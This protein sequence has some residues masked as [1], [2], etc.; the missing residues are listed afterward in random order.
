[1]AWLVW[2]SERQS[3]P[4]WDL[5]WSFSLF[6][7]CY[8]SGLSKVKRNLK[9]NRSL[10]QIRSVSVVLEVH[11]SFEW[12]TSSTFTVITGK[13]SI[14]VSY[15]LWEYVTSIHCSV[16]SVYHLLDELPVVH[17]VIIVV[18]WY[19]KFSHERRRHVCREW[20]ATHVSLVSLCICLVTT[21]LQR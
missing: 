2:F 1:M 5:A 4:V 21:D 6:E 14:L 13:I 15:S 9:L 20:W 18:L 10:I 7:S 3:L 11:D 12:C 8:Q 17:W 19:I 16:S